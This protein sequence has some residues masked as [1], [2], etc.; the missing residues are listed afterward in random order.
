MSIFIIKY[1][2]L[3]LWGDN[4]IKKGDIVGRKSYGK[5][6]IFSV[7]RIIDTKEGKIAILKGII[8]RVEADSSVDDLEVIDRKL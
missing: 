6:V 3:D 4:M 7:K 5:D 8:E 2:S 1:N